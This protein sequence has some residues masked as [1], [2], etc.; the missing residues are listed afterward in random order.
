MFAVTRKLICTPSRFRLISRPVLSVML[1]LAPVAAQSKDANKGTSAA[2]V[3]PNVGPFSPMLQHGPSLGVAAGDVLNN[4]SQK[5]DHH[6]NIID[7]QDPLFLPAKIYGTGGWEA[8][9]FAV[10]DV[11]GDKIP[12]ILATNTYYL[13]TIGVLRGRGDG[14]FGGRSTYDSGGDSP[15]SIA[16]LDLNRD[17][18]TDLVVSNQ[19]TCYACTGDGVIAVLLGNDKLSFQLSATYSSGGA[20]AGSLVVADVNLDGNPDV[21]VTN[22]APS[23]RQDL[24]GNGPNGII[25]VLLGTAAGTFQPAVT[26]ATGALANNGLG[27]I[28]VADVN[29]DGKPDV[30]V[31]ECAGDCPGSVSVLFGNGNGTFQ[32]P[33]HYNSGGRG[34]GGIAVADLNGDGKLDLVVGACGSDCWVANGV[35]G[36]LLGNGNGTFQSPVTYDSGGAYADSV[37]IADVD[38]DGKLDIL[39]SNIVGESVSVLRGNGN[40]TFQSPLTYAS[41]GNLTYTIKAADLNGD[42]HPDLIV[43][44]CGPS[45]GGCGYGVTGVVGVLLNNSLPHAT[46]TSLRTSASPSQVGE[47]VTFTATV[48]SQFGAIPDGDLVTFSD[49]NTSLGSVAL[50][51]GRASLTTSSLAPKKHYIKATY[52]GNATFMSSSRTITQ[53]VVG[54]TTSTT[55]SSFPNPSNLGQAVTFTAQVTSTGPV[56]TGK[57][58]FLDGAVAIGTATLNNGVAKLIR[59]T[60][61]VGTHPIT[62]KYMGDAV[63]EKSTSS[64]VNQVVNP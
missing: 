33:T 26:Y 5:M 53:I 22:C 47:P 39:V 48:S 55:L 59:S 34:A 15:L 52:N 37:A 25:S 16:T 61:T 41:G 63:S 38:G 18:K 50:T 43:S 32:S 54:Y 13:D 30:V 21:V 4:G 29:G 46:T 2:H 11:S 60:L 19:T 57:V 64:T 23:G 12:D 9:S 14:T 6:A 35:V 27:G 7:T 1:L 8:I 17:G 58:K 28:A 56:P 36:V 3:L 20:Y 62:A 42:G 40:G 31:T 51:G 24:C 44:S 45:G 10:V 49:G